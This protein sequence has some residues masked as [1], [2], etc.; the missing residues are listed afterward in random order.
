MRMRLARGLAVVVAAFGMVGT[1]TARD[2]D[3]WVLAAVMD[4][5]VG[6]LW[7]VRQSSATPPVVTLEERVEFDGTHEH[8][9]IGFQRFDDFD[10]GAG[11]IERGAARAYEAESHRPIS[12]MLLYARGMQ[13]PDFDTEPVRPAPGSYEERLLQVACVY[14]AGDP[15]FDALPRLDRPFYRA[16]AERAM[17]AFDRNYRP[18]TFQGVAV[19]TAEDVF[20]VTWVEGEPSHAAAVARLEAACKARGWTCETVASRQCVA[21]GSVRSPIGYVPG[22]GATADEARNEVAARCEEAGV[23]CTIESRCP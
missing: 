3:E 10:C 15:A 18:R 8:A 4:D 6:S 2:P 12:A 17:A 21:L 11:T 23:G 5:A 7:L 22:V 13:S 1:A 14:A 16:D 9:G 20:G 19:S